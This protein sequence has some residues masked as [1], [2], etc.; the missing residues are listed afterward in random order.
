M[1]NRGE[2]NIL[3]ES[4]IDVYK[5]QTLA[6]A[7]MSKKKEFK[8]ISLSAALQAFLG[9]DEP[10]LYGILLPLKKP[11]L[12]SLAGGFVGGTVAG[13][14]GTKAYACLLYTSRCV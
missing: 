14:L 1:K 9:T 4:R 8:G 10:A 3:E 7:L 11:F 12:A 13:F 2:N 6:V 5:R